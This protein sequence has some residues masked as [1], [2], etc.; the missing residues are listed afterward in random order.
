VARRRPP[1]GDDGADQGAAGD[2]EGDGRHGLDAHRGYAAGGYAFVVSLLAF[3]LIKALIGLRVAPD[4]EI[5]GLDDG[6]HGM[7]AYPDFV[8]A[9]EAM[10][11]G[12]VPGAP[13]SGAR[14][15]GYA[16]PART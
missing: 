14:A 5:E 1:P 13:S 7:A 16:Q 4:E 9:A 3:G 8:I 10:G 6:E 12:G 15:A 2:T 11:Q